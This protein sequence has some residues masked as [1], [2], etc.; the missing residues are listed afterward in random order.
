MFFY[1]NNNFKYHCC[2]KFQRIL[3]AARFKKYKKTPIQKFNNIE[4]NRDYYFLLTP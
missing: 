4:K 3:K 2:F 1:R